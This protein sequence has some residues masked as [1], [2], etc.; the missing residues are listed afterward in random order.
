MINSALEKE[1]HQCTAVAIFCWIHCSCCGC[2]VSEICCVTSPIKTNCHHCGISI[3][4]GYGE[5][6]QSVW[7]GLAE[8][9]SLFANPEAVLQWMSV[10]SCSICTLKRTAA[11]CR[12]LPP[13]KVSV[14][15]MEHMQVTSHSNDPS[16]IL[17]FLPLS[18]K[19]RMG[20]CCHLA[21]WIGRQS[22]AFVN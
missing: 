14:C 4:A 22:E 11:W 16:I 17:L 3:L 7:A 8:Y 6:V 1:P 15:I 9:L 12:S 13:V 19:G 5:G 18:H 21:S 20:C 2:A 10:T